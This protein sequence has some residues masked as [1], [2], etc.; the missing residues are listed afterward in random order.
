MAFIE[1]NS[2]A[3]AYAIVALLAAGLAA[4]VVVR[5]ARARAVR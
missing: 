4:Y 3:V 2:K 1:D 5:K